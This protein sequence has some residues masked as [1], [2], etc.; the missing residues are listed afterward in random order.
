MCIYNNKEGEKNN[1]YF[2]RVIPERQNQQTIQAVR[3]T[4]TG[5]ILTSTGDILQEA[6]RFYTTLYSPEDI[7]PCCRFLN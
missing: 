7:D 5:K 3:S 1:K 6:H 2:Y 4:T